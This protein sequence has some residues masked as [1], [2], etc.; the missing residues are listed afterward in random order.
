MLTICIEYEEKNNKFL[1][2]ASYIIF[3]CKTRATVRVF[4]TLLLVQ[5]LKEKIREPLSVQPSC[6]RCLSSGHICVDIICS[7]CR[8]HFTVTSVQQWRIKGKNP[9]ADTTFCQ[10]L[11]YRY[12]YNI[13]GHTELCTSA[14]RDR[15]W[16]WK[17]ISFGGFFLC[18][19][20]EPRCFLITWWRKVTLCLSVCLLVSGCVC[21]CVECLPQSVHLPACRS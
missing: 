18:V 4:S 11:I 15:G 13:R 16:H 5:I 3:Y 17:H 19:Y 21:E 1:Q 12:S 9:N 8:I 10:V 6:S 20:V 14:E 7:F 2:Y